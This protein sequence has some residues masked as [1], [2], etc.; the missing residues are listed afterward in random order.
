MSIDNNNL[1]SSARLQA[2]FGTSGADNTTTTTQ[3]SGVSFSDWAGASDI[4]RADGFVSG[5][6]TDIASQV[7]RHLVQAG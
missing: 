5:S 7:T 2:R 1:V 3:H 6:V 4:I